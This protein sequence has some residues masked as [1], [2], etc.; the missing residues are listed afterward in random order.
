MHLE[1]V[2]THTHDL[3]AKWRA[4]GQAL[5]EFRSLS[6]QD[7]SNCGDVDLFQSIVPLAAGSLNIDRRSEIMMSDPVQPVAN[8]FKHVGGQ[9]T[10]CRI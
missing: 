8:L 10:E 9:R 3:R 5:S 1:D 6:H 4:I 2:I 7:T